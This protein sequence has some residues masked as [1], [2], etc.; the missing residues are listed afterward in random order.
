MGQGGRR[1]RLTAASG[2]ATTLGCDDM[3]S[4]S[5]GPSASQ[6][7][8]ALLDPQFPCQQNGDK[9]LNHSPVVR[10][11]WVTHIKSSHGAR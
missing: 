4:A 1:A 3:M 2:R 11:K 5:H 10:T 6:T 8:N 7:L 9:E